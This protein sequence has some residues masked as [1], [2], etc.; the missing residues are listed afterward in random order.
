LR[1]AAVYL[2]SG[3]LYGCE[4]EEGFTCRQYQGNVVNIMNSAV[5]VE[6]PASENRHHYLVMLQSNVLKRNSSVDHQTLATR[7][8]V[9]ITRRPEQP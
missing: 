2:K 3:S 4:P 7:I 1:D 9:L 6:S 8:H 5:M